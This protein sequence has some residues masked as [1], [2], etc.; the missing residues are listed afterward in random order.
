VS[1]WDDLAPRIF[2]F[3]LVFLGN[4]DEASAERIS[5]SLDLLLAMRVRVVFVRHQVGVHL[6]GGIEKLWV[7]DA[8]NEGCVA[9]DA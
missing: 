4:L 7:G 5:A 9:G 3:L 1:S 8:G 6:V 2:F